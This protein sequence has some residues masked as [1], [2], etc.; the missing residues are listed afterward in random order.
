[1]LHLQNTLESAGYLY[2]P[3]T[4]AD[5]WGTPNM[6]NL[7]EMNRQNLPVGADDSAIPQLANP[8][9][10]RPDY[11]PGSS[12]YKGGALPTDPSMGAVL[13][14]GGGNKERRVGTMPAVQTA[15]EMSMNE[16]GFTLML[17]AGVLAAALY[18]QR[19]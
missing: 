13:N 10:G 9:F 19:T 12:V 8:S 4:Q 5:I 15:S 2:N 3:F 7:Q 17:F 16:Q 14:H 11:V 18:F 1:M 6:L